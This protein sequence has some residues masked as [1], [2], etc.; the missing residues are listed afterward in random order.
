MERAHIIVVSDL[1]I[2]A[3]ALDDFDSELEGHFVRFLEDELAHR[4]CALELVI[5][6]DFLDFV[7]APPHAGRN[8]Q[9]QSKEELPLCFTQPQSREKLAAI[10]AAHE[11][12]FR[13]LRRYL[14]VNSDNTLVVLPGNHDPDFFWPKVREDFIG[15]VSGNDAALAKRICIHLQQAYRPSKCREVWIEHGHQYDPLN[16]FLISEHSC[17]SEENPPILSDGDTERLY[18]CLGTRFL[19]DYLNDLDATYPFVDNVKPFSRFVRLFLASVA[20]FHFGPMKAAVAGWRILRYLSSLAAT[21]PKDLLGVEKIEDKE[22]AGLLVRLKKVARSKDDMFDRINKAYPGDRDLR[23]LLEN[24]TEQDHILDWLANH[25]DLLEEPSPITEGNLLGVDAADDEYL[26]L[27]K[28][29]R[30]DE[31]ALLVDAATGLLSHLSQDPVKLVIMGHTHEP[32]ERPGGLNYY[33]TGSWTRYFRF[34]GD[35]RPSSWSMLKEQSYVNFP[36]KL[37]YVDIDISDPSAAQMI[38]FQGRDH[39]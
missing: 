22:K 39:D 19:I 33:N 13:A 11:P 16:S 37:N 25:L 21:H 29:F 28:G 34:D 1:H 9:A 12:T 7:Q 18:A 4:R 20:D 26:S 27:S 14:A 23:I 10:Y 36:F 6:G 24:S 30:L 2:S 3:A 5:N 8:L 17:W 31:T 38:C 32:V 15:L 35:G